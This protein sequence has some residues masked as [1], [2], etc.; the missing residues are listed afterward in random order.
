[1][2]SGQK[3][4]FFFILKAA[5]ILIYSIAFTCR[6]KISGEEKIEALR[7]GG[8]PIIYIF[9]HR[10]IFYN[11][12]KFRGTNARPLISFSTDGEIVSRIAE[13]FGMN[14]IRGS[15]SHGGA[16]AFINMIN[17]IKKEN[18]EIMITAD[19]PKGPVRE[20]KDGTVHIARK[21][22]AA[23]VPVSWYASRVKIFDKS[24]DKFILPI[25]FGRI[26]FSFGDPVYIPPGISKNEY[27]KYKNMLKIKLDKLEEE[28][29][30][31]IKKS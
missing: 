1:M 4:K 22:G 17:A 30:S 10:H 9:W 28:I 25:P 3:I 15:S 16:R 6:K 20:I 2:G 18:S 8:K 24:W 26:N 23:I 27:P 12:F 21:T 5:K 11:I 29:I 31:R 14:P 13:E 7:N 19:G